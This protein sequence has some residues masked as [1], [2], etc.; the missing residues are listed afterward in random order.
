MRR[1]SVY[2]LALLMLVAL[3]VTTTVR[4]DE[5]SK[6]LLNLNLPKISLKKSECCDD[7]E[8]CCSVGSKLFS[9]AKSLFKKTE[10]TGEEDC[11]VC[12]AKKESSEDCDKAAKKLAG[13]AGNVVKDGAEKAKETVG[14][15]R[16]RTEKVIGKIR[17]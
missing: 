13:K 5:D 2:G 7:K 17:K 4:A 1:L 14:K 8:G 10:C 3:V 12:N 15:L 11:P 6:K 16:E 9:R